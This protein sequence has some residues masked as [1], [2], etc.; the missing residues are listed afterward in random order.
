[1]SPEERHRAEAIIRSALSVE[2]SGPLPPPELLGKYEALLPGAADRIIR[3]A[4]TQQTHRQDLERTV[5][6]SNV[7]VQKWGLACGFV[8]ALT[9]ISGGIWLS[10]RGSSGVGLTA[11]ISALAALV[12]VFIYGKSEQRKEL[13]EKSEAIAEAATTHQPTP[14]V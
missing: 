14:Q 1:V 4:E 9:A 6:K 2:F 7:S 5:I 13:Q 11:I 10:L 3:M 8:L 12:G